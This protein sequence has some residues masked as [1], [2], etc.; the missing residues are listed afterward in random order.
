MMAAQVDGHCPR[1]DYRVLSWIEEKLDPIGK[2]SFKLLRRLDCIDST[3]G[4]YLQTGTFHCR[5]S[6]AICMYFMCHAAEFRNTSPQFSSFPFFPFLLQL[7]TP[8]RST[9]LSSPP[10]VFSYSSFPSPFL[11]FP[12][13]LLFPFSFPSWDGYAAGFEPSSGQCSCTVRYDIKYLQCAQKLS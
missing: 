13:S 4:D 11:L 1:I 10:V 3:A 12:A 6:N 2:E 8:F 9:P 5:V 7:P